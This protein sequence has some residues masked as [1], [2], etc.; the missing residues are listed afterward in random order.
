MEEILKEKYIITS[1]EPVSLEKS[2]KIN[3]QMKKYICRIY[4]NNCTGTGFFIKIQHKSKLL[5]VLMTNNHIIDLKN[6]QNNKIITIFI[7]EENKERFIKINEQ[8]LLYTNEKL[9]VTIIGLNEIEDNIKHYLELD[10]S[11]IDSFQL[12]EDEY[13]GH[14]KNLYLNQSI[15][16]LNYPEE[17]NIVVSYGKLTSINKNEINHKCITKEGSS[18]S[19]IL[20]LKSNKVIGIHYGCSKNFDLN[21]GTLIIYAIFDLINNENNSIFHNKIL[22]KKIADNLQNKNNIFKEKD[23]LDYNNFNKN[24][25]T[26]IFIKNND[27]NNIIKGNDLLNNNNFNE[28][29]IINNNFIK[30]NNII[31]IIKIND[32]LNDNNYNKNEKIK[33]LIKN[34]D[35]NK[36]IEDNDLSNYIYFNKNKKANDFIKNNIIKDDVLLNFNNYNKN[37]N[38]NDFIKNNDKNNIIKDNDILNYK[39]FNKNEKTKNFDKNYFYYLSSIINIEYTFSNKNFLGMGFLVE[40]PIM[41]NYKIKG[42][43][44]SYELLNENI[45]EKIS[46]IKIYSNNYEI[47]LKLNTG[48]IFLDKFLNISFFENPN[49]DINYLEIEENNVNIL[50]KKIIIYKNSND[51]KYSKCLGNIKMKWG[52]LL[53][54]TVKTN[55]ELFG[56]PI[57]SD[58]NKVIGIHIFSENTKSTGINIQFIRQAIRIAKLSGLD[59]KYNIVREP[60]ILTEFKISKLKSHGLIKTQNP[61]IFIS[62][63]S[64]NITPLWFYRTRYAWYWTPTMPKEDNIY[65]SN[66]LIIYPGGSLK[67]I[68]GY[69]D[70][71]EPAERNIDLIH[72][73]EKSKLKFL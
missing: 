3:E 57:F 24:V 15:Y 17:K 22:E 9:D 47:Q 19:P 2:E 5:P 55:S 59:Y 48:F 29:E 62:P 38:S 71:I 26:N 36:I 21:K 6:I 52:F 42:L 66:W 61:N 20:L 34:T 4:Y 43:I 60:K 31:N 33:N 39:N 13:E 35:K 70:G 67:V 30:N 11:V 56:S 32:S 27:K 54:H 40:I 44:T 16:I 10:N 45:L 1:P 53:F 12:T 51:Y 72:W 68:G 8:R 69:W 65:D 64:K 41:K 25:K 28:K 14:L 50:E 73:L 37:K 7:N 49:L 18:G 23:L 58:K 46:G 63:S